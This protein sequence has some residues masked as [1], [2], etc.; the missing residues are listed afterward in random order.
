MN[1][2][3]LLSSVACSV[4]SLGPEGLG[5]VGGQQQQQGG[6]KKTGNKYSAKPTADT[7]KIMSE[8]RQDLQ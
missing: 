1:T 5:E 3:L 8:D 4:G 2:L 6:G 7:L